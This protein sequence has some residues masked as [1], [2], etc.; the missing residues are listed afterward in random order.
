MALGPAVEQCGQAA[1][2]QRLVLAHPLDGI[3]LGVG[4]PSY[5]PQNASVMKR[6]VKP[7]PRG[8]APDR[9]A[10]LAQYRRRASVYDLELAAFEPIRRRAIA[11]LELRPGQTVLDVGCGTGLSFEPI[12]SAIG[13]KGRLIGIEQSPDMME[14]A[15]H[16]VS[17]MGWRNVTLI[18]APVEE[19]KIAQAADAAL[20]FFTHDVLRCPEAVDVIVKHLKSHARLVAAGL[21][22]APLWAWPANL[23]VWSA[24]QH[25]VTS[26]EGL[27]APWTP[28]VARTEGLDVQTMMLGSIYIARAR[29]G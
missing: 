28:L 21:K 9:D 29:I 13:V 1:P 4:G 11:E 25:S 19:A 24:A 14:R 8:D 12:E 16:R 10:A 17:R 22:W 23:F 2:R 5:R 6:S 7:D 20:L 18:C 3:G 26:M 27:D 15:R